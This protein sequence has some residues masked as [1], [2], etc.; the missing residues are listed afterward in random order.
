MASDFSTIQNICLQLNPYGV[1]TRYPNE[2]AID[3]L[4]TK[5]AIDRAQTILDFGVAK[6]G[7]QTDK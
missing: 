5:N 6:I 2:L 7:V 4:V 3:E 1:V